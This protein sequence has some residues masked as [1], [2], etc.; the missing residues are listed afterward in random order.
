VCCAYTTLTVQSSCCDPLV[1]RRS[2]DVANQALAGSIPGLGAIFVSTST[3]NNVAVVTARLT[4][5]LFNMLE[6]VWTDVWPQST[7]FMDYVAGDRTRRLWA[8]VS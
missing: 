6:V 8:R 5:S 2:C 7:T 4:S 3:S 1:R